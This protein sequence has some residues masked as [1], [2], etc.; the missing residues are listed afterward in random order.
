MLWLSV[1]IVSASIPIFLGL[2]W[3]HSLVHCVG[4]GWG[5][6]T[7]HLCSSSILQIAHPGLV[8]ELILNI[9]FLKTLLEFFSY[10]LMLV[11]WAFEEVY[12]CCVRALAQCALLLVCWILENVAGLEGQPLMHE[13]N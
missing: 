10:V 3:F 12:C 1:H 5:L 8:A 7:C 9:D 6:G 13:L 4:D 11:M 2:S